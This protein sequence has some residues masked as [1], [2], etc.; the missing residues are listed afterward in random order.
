MFG[1]FCCP[2]SGSDDG[3]DERAPLL[4]PAQEFG[5]STAR[6]VYVFGALQ[7]QLRNELWPTT[8]SAR[9]HSGR[10]LGIRKAGKERKFETWMDSDRY[11]EQTSESMRR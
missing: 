1:W 5:E 2:S 6:L 4:K 9:K 8:T 3:F 11:N 10:L 7:G